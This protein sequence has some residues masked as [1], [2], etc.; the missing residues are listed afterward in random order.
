MDMHLFALLLA[1]VALTSRVVADT[2]ANCTFEDV[3]GTW[4]FQIG[5]RGHDKTI[6]CTK[7]G[8]LANTL[9]WCPI[10]LNSRPATGKV[11]LRVESTTGTSH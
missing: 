11:A 8:K 9:D 10:D 1:L 6:N 3:K 2:P 7:M 5:S 4:I